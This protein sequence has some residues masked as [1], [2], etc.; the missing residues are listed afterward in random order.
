MENLKFHIGDKVLIVKTRH[1]SSEY[2]N[3]IN[4]IGKIAD[5]YE[6]KNIDNYIIRYKVEFENLYNDKEANGLFIY[7]QNELESLSEQKGEQIKMNGLLKIYKER[8]MA[9]LN[10]VFESKVM[11]EV[12]TS[13]A[14]N[15]LVNYCAK[16]PEVNI[17]ITAS[18]DKKFEESRKKEYENFV[19]EHN[20]LDSLIEEVDAQL[21]ICDSYEQKIMCLYRYGIV[22]S[23]Y[24][25]KD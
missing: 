2:L 17:D 14:Y 7:Y 24:R 22:D 13:N 15:D 1:K 25:L 3:T 4:K 19:K 12:T 16:Y 6:F 8:K 20:K 21:N 23:K 11:S 5:V 9:S 10:A 18:L